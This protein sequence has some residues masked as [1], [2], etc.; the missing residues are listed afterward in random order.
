LLSS[1]F[2]TNRSLYSFGALTLLATFFCQFV[3]EFLRYSL[4]VFVSETDFFLLQNNFWVSL[5][6][7]G[8][9]NLILMLVLFYIFNFVSNR[10]RPVFIRG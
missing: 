9:M 4:E 5:G 10:F 1:S 7:A 8:V 3:F 6:K 2:F